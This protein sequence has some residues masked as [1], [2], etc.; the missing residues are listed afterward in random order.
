MNIKNK[1]VSV[2]TVFVLTLVGCTSQGPKETV[3]TDLKKEY[4]KTVVVQDIKL[5]LFSSYTVKLIKG[6]LYRKKYR[7]KKD[8][9]SPHLMF[10]I[11][12]T[13]NTIRF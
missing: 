7:L 4:V 13:A 9:M 11:I 6:I 12:R 1:I 8:G 2:F 3:N 10:M 5:S